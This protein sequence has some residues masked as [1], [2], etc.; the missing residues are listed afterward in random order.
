[1][2]PPPLQLFHLSLRPSSAPYVPSLSSPDCREEHVEVLD[3]GEDDG[4]MAAHDA[5][6][7]ILEEPRRGGAEA[8]GYKG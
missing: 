3:E 6:H 5:R 4:V 2:P 8:E 1:M 7:C